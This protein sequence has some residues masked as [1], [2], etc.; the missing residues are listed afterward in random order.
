VKPFDLILGCEVVYLAESLSP[1]LQTLKTMSRPDSM[2]LFAYKGYR[3]EWTDTVFARFL[4][5]L[6]QVFMLLSLSLIL[7][8]PG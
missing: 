4:T 7:C 1:L 6:S 2:F 3:P 8:S 5:M